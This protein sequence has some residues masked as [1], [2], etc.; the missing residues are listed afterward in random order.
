MCGILTTSRRIEGIE[1]VT[2]YLHRR[3]PD[4]TNHVEVNGIEFVHTLLSITGNPSPQPFINEN[5]NIVA[6]YNGEIYN[7]QN[8]GDFTSDGHCIIPMY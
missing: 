3:G 7:Y 4:L 6:S 8:F 5:R 2:E 1:H